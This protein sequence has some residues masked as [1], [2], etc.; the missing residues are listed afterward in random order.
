M[1]GPFVVQRRCRNDAC[2]DQLAQW[3]MRKALLLTDSLLKSEYIPGESRTIGQGGGTMET[4]TNFIN[5]RN[6]VIDE[7][8]IVVCL[9]TNTIYKSKEAY[10]EHIANLL[11]TLRQKAPLVPIM[12]LE[13]PI[14]PL[15]SGYDFTPVDQRGIKKRKNF[16]KRLRS[17]IKKFPGVY[18]RSVYKALTVKRGKNR[19]AN[20]KSFFQDGLHLSRKGKAD[21][22]NAIIQIL[23]LDLMK[24]IDRMTQQ[25]TTFRPCCP[26]RLQRCPVNPHLRHAN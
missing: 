24:I 17:I 21:V 14:R 22:M 10:K 16:N 11:V 9:G 26:C 20:P 23:S 5:S 2:N 7:Q 18:C 3:G 1:P 25:R 15:E 13:V 12:W 4:F 8:V 19:V 6:V